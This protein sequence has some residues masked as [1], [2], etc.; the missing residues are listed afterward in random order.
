MKVAVVG[1]THGELDALYAEV[2]RRNASAAPL[3]RIRLLLCCGDFE[4]LRNTHDL[5]CKASPPRYRH[6]NAFP[7]YYSGAKRASVLTIFI[8]GNHEASN[9][10]QELHYGGWVAPK[11][12]YLGAAG[13]IN[14][15]GI[16]I[17]GL[18]GI[19]HAR[20]Y[21]KGHFERPPYS[22]DALHSV[23]CVRELEVLQLAHL[24]RRIDVFLS[25]DWPKR[26]EDHGDLAA[27]LEERP[28][29]QQSIDA[30]RF[31]NAGSER[32]LQTLRPTTWLAGHMHVGFE[33]VVRHPATSCSGVASDVDE[34]N[35][36]TESS[37]S[38]QTHFLGLSKCMPGQACL[39]VADLSP[40]GHSG[41]YERDSVDESE[42][43]DLRVLM[44]VEWLA[45]LRATH[46][47]A[48][49]SRQPVRLPTKLLALD[50]EWVEQRLDEVYIRPEH[51][52]RVRGEW[53]SDFVK[54][55]PALGESESARM[56]DLGNP[57]TDA[58]LELLQLPHV[59]TTPYQGEA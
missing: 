56:Y 38:E 34:S 58:L 16:R 3:D 54:T 23:Y 48:T 4:S 50:T 57:Q 59:V 28:G 6:M 33:A 47:L 36:T 2:D 46:H 44:D 12:F 30:N 26:I 13:A 41:A 19:Y 11:M 9:Y 8:G 5:A 14:V 39:E 55:A 25:H 43:E 17:A 15:G 51:A 24:T 42:H 52:H 18:S 21:R 35:T 45:V 32:L 40:P 29:F 31:G 53:P 49:R 7:E 1:C 20:H 10:L 37:C 22:K 27:L